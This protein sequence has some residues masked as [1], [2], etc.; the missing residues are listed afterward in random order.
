MFRYFFFWGGCSPIRGWILDCHG[1][2]RTLFFGDNVF[3]IWIERCVAGCDGALSVRK[4]NAFPVENCV[5]DINWR[6][7]R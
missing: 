4:I 3:L 2:G 1:R 7:G 5:F 6:P